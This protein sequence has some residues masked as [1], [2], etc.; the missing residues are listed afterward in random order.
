MQN[1]EWGFW[2]NMKFAPSTS[3]YLKF[4]LNASSPILNATSIS[5]Y[6][7]QIGEAN[8]DTVKLFRQ[9][10]T[11]K[12]KILSSTR[13]CQSSTTAN[14]ANV[15]IKVERDDIGKWTIYSDCS[16]GQNFIVDGNV[17]DNTY[18]IPGFMGPNCIYGTTT[19]YNQFQFDDIIFSKKVID[20]SPPEI[21]SISAIDPNKIEILF[22]EDIDAESILNIDNFKLNGIDV[23]SSISSLNSRKIQIK[24]T[25]QFLDGINYQLGIN[26]V[27]DLVGNTLNNTYFFS[28][29]KPFQL[30]YRDILINEIYADES[31]SNGLPDCEYVELYNKTNYPIDL[32]GFTIKDGT[33]NRVIN[34]P[35]TLAGLGFLILCSSNANAS[36]LKDFDPSLLVVTISGLSLTNTGDQIQLIDNVGRLLDKVN[37]T[38]DWYKDKE[39]SNGGWSIEQINP[40]RPCTD[41]NNWKASIATIGGTPGKSNSV[42]STLP[43]TIKPKIIS[44]N[45]LK[46]TIWSVSFSKPVGLASLSTSSIILSHDLTLLSIDSIFEDGTGFRFHFNQTPTLGKLYSFQAFNISDC[47]GNT[48][49]TSKFMFGSGRKPKIYELI[50]NELLA[51]ETPSVGLPDGEFIEL[52]NTTGDLI[53]LD[54]LRIGNHS[55]F[56]KLPNIKILPNEYII[57]TSNTNASKYTNYGRSIGLSNFPSLNNASDKI[58][59]LDSKGNSIHQVSYFDTWYGDENKKAGGWTLELIDPKNPCG[60]STNWKASKDTRGG[61]PGV[62]NSNYNSNPDVYAPIIQKTTVIDSVSLNI[63]LNEQLDSTFSNNPVY[64]FEGE[65][66]TRSWKYI[67]IEHDQIQI[68]F[69]KPITINNIQSLTILGL[70]DCIGNSMPLVSTFVRPGKAEVGDL[71]INE[72]LFNPY[73]GG[74]DFVEIYNRGSNYLDLDGWKIANIQHDTISNRKSISTNH[75]LISPN[76]FLAITTDTNNIKNT[77]PRSVSRNMTQLASLPSFN[78]DAGNV[79]LLMPNRTIAEKFS[80]NENMHFKLLSDKE[81]V[82]LERISPE[83]PVNDPSSWHSAASSIGFAT[84]GFANSQ[85][86]GISGDSDPFSVMPQSF[87]PDG[88]GNQDFTIIAYLFSSI[89]NT[90]NIT[91]FD[92]KGRK[93]KTIAQN[94]LL[95]SEGNYQWDG[96]D[97]GGHKAAI[98]V[99][100]IHAEVFD[101]KGKSGYY[102]NKVA[103]GAKFH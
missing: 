96:T 3:N 46:G 56:A 103:V 98:G 100:L 50:I 68:Q 14:Y 39:K 48:L 65:N 80:Y 64:N 84:P 37:Y 61:T 13:V 18:S 76:G 11:T 51:K 17:I 29:T 40:F 44:L 79:I 6:Y 1:V 62:Q 15:R 47:S 19:R 49:D 4:Y 90:A 52:Y 85:M 21:I 27:K 25:I 73:P 70:A 33:V 97:D 9:N 94:A 26:N 77:Y 23:P 10:G 82:S 83:L 24:F 58:L 38:I 35:I 20:V 60:R 2:A 34:Q 53:S 28:Y 91:I 41:P 12:T 75:L 95:S 67:S 32:K 63:Q 66:L 43:D 59:L 22:S 72:V 36:L 16:G 71:I 42:F 86:A 87:T 101:L 92:P 99:Y 57:L 45:Q 74:A 55:Q 93:V 7:I 89:G 54:S 8:R 69:D 81:G 31:P 78:D 102:I 30:S 88:D 5:G